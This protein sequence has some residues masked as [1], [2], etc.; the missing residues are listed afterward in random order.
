[1][2]NVAVSFKV[3]YELAS[4]NIQMCGICVTMSGLLRACI[5]S[6][7]KNS[8]VFLGEC[9]ITEVTKLVGEATAK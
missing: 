2:G 5:S 9:E 6:M 4:R 7:S 1:M 8:N 3:F